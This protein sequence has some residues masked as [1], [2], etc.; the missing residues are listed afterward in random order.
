MR[1]MIAEDEVRLAEAVARGLRRDG[2]AVDVTH[3][4]AGALAKARVVRYDVVL[5]DRDLPVLHGDEV[6][7]TLAAERP[8][9]RV[10]RRPAGGERGG[11]AEGL[12]LG[13]DDYAAKPFAFEV[14]AAGV[15]ARGRRAG[16]PRPPVLRRGD[17][18]LD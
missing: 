17:V 15:R 3:D 8:A 18:E 2:H 5:L 12:A 7:R 16:P 11:V 9:A 4:G 13:A 10:L 1:V 14:L 6:C